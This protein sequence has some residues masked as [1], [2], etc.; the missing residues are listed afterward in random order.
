MAEENKQE[1][2]K[3]EE[4]EEHG[5]AALFC[6]A[7]YDDEQII[8]SKPKSYLESEGWHYIGAIQKADTLHIFSDTNVV[9]GVE[10][11]FS[12]PQRINKGYLSD[13]MQKFS[14]HPLP[15]G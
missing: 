5:L 12:E 8:E 9:Y 13:N 1:A 7:D 10:G 3:V 4:E 15:E 11:N 6:D 2:P 14:N